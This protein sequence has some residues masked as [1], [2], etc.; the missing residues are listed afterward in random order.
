[1]VEVAGRFVDAEASR[2]PAANSYKIIY[3]A[4]DSGPLGIDVCN[5]EASDAHVNIYIVPSSV[6]YVDGAV[7]PAYSVV[8]K[9]Q[10]V[11]SDGTDGNTW[12]MPVKHINT[13]DVVVV[14]TDLLNVT[15]YPHGIRGS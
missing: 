8:H 6:G 14:R 15:F 4:P 12:V 13:G 1:M 2:L 10:R 11:E 7:P 3:T 9:N 5:G